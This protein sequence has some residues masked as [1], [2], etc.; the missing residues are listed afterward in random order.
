MTATHAGPL[1]F[2]GKSFKATNKKVLGAPECLSYTFNEQGKCTGFTGGVFAFQHWCNGMQLVHMSFIYIVSTCCIC[3][4]AMQ[5]PLSFSLLSLEVI[6][7]NK[8]NDLKSQIFDSFTGRDHLL[9]HVNMSTAQEGR[10]MTCHT[11][12]STFVQYLSFACDK[13]SCC[14]GYIM[15]RRVGNT[16]KMGALFGILAAIGGPIPEP[17]TIPYAFFILSNRLSDIF[18]SELL[19]IAYAC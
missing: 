6:F 8:A 10:C 3:S 15:D 16:K 17:E 14:A 5:L 4:T 9:Q 18:K 2:F 13:Y 11:H 7:H 12:T 19:V 1:K